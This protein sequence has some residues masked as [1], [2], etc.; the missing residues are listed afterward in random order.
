[1]MFGNEDKIPTTG[2]FTLERGHLVEAKEMPGKGSINDW[3][4][5]LGI[6]RNHIHIVFGFDSM[7]IECIG[8]K[9]LSKELVFVLAKKDSGTILMSDINDLK[10]R[11]DWDFEYSS[12]NVED[13]LKD[14][15]ELEN[16]DFDFLSSVIDLQPDGKDTYRSDQLGLY[17][18]FE[19]NILK[20]F[21][22][23]DWDNSAT[24][25]LR[26]L[27]DTMVKSMTME[28]ELFHSN[29]IDIVEE[30]NEQSNALLEIPNGVANEFLEIH[31]TVYGN[32]NFYNLLIAHYEKDCTIDEFLF[33]N[34]G[35]FTTVDENTFEIGN[36]LYRFSN[37]GRIES[38]KPKTN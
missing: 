14:G 7:N 9:T 34:K 25:W 2:F 32:I 20:A 8:F 29:K 17:L 12:L 3:I 28:A 33:V 1:M 37:D 26:N 36:F 21:A 4:Q 16:F 22:S 18:Q 30:V 35:R 19:N 31:R 24:K 27:N 13:I 10:K 23:S 6:P 38:I 5:S 15:I 11:I